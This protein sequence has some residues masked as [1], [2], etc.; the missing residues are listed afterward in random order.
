MRVAHARLRMS[1]AFDSAC[2]VLR[3]G[4]TVYAQ[5]PC[6]VEKTADSNASYQG[7]NL[8]MGSFLVSVPVN[9]TI[10]EG[11]DLIERGRRLRVISVTSPTSYE[12]RREVIAIMVGYIP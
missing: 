5:I 4:S 10:I 2:D 8:P 7:D 3:G 12:I 11:D 6:M 9:Y 1:A